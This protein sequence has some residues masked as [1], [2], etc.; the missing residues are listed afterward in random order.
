MTMGMVTVKVAEAL[1]AGT[2][3]TSL[4]DMTIAYGPDEMVGTLNVHV[5]APAAVV[6]W[7]VQVCVPRVAPLNVIVPM[8]VDTENPEPVTVTGVPIGP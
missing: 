3:P 8:V 5:N 6:V 7:E 4:P 2:V 1:S